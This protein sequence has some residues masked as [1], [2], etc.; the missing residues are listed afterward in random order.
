MAFEAE[1]DFWGQGLLREGD[2]LDEE[3]DSLLDG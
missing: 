2:E 1:K 3:E